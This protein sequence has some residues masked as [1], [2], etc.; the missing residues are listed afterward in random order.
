MG[1]LF[2]RLH[3]ALGVFVFLFVDGYFFLSISPTNDCNVVVKRCTSPVDACN[4]V[5]LAVV[6]PSSTPGR[7]LSASSQ[8]ARNLV[9]VASILTNKASS[10]FGT[11][12]MFFSTGM[13]CSSTPSTM[14]MYLTDAFSST[15]TE[16][17]NSTAIS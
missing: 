2:I 1:Y 10:F 11:R 17:V 3:R 7:T 14:R 16:R 4:L 15:C 12:G 5:M 13:T 6:R 9:V 8:A